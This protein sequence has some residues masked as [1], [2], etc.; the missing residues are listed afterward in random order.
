ML[1]INGSILHMERASL[2]T[3]QK[4]P[5]QWDPHRLW[6]LSIVSTDL[7]LLSTDLNSKYFYSYIGTLGVSSGAAHDISNC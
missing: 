1:Y 5:M 7:E 6:I 4:T 3:A 2:I